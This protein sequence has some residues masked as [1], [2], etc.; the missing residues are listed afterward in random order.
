MSQHSNPNTTQGKED[1][2]SVFGSNG[3]VGSAYCRRFPTAVV[4]IPRS[5][6]L[7]SGD[8]SL[9]FISTVTNYNV[10]E[11]LHLD[12]D[13]N[14]KVLMEVLKNVQHGHM[15]NFISSWFVYGRPGLPARETDYCDPKGFYS[16][17]KRTAEQLLI[18][19]CETNKVN[20]RILRLCN[21]YGL[22]DEKASKQKN[23]MQWLI[24]QLK[25]NQPIS[26]YDNGYIL[27]EYMHVNDVADAIHLVLTKGDQN[28]I[29]NIGPDKPVCLRYIID[30]AKD[31][32]GSTSEISAIP[33]PEFHNIVQAR[34]FYMDSS[35]LCRLGFSP[36]VSLEIGIRELCAS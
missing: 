20:Y 7:P 21:V 9:Y 14:L 24:G 25:T 36:K 11:N 33:M 8:T 28:T 27:R 3:F 22:N 15:F 32:L 16:I 4:Q 1:T 23:A 26:L 10:H 34:D 18:S 17:T 31:F 6:R 5:E 19:F 30:T 12:I 2:L 35:K 29:Y 13:T